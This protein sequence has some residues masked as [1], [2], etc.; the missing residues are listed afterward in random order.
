MTTMLTTETLEQRAASGDRRYYDEGRVQ[1]SAA[2]CSAFDSAIRRY[3]IFTLAFLVLGAVELAVCLTSFALLVRSSLLAVSL[4]VMF[5]T[6]FSYFIL[7]LY[8]QSRKEEQF[9]EILEGAEAQSKELIGYQEGDAEHHLFLANSLVRCASALK[10]KEYTYYHPPEML[11]VLGP[12]AEQ[13]SCWWHW[14]DLHKM[15]ELFLQRAIDEQIKLV[16]CEPTDLEVHAGLANTYVLLSSLYAPP[17]PGADDERWIPPE[18]SSAAMKERFRATAQR[19]IEEF[20]ILNHY[21][22][23]DPWI[24]AQLAYSY[25]DM[26]MPEEEIRC[27]ET[28]LRLKPGDVETQLKLGMLYFQQGQNAKGLQ[29]YEGLKRSHHK[30]AETLLAFYGGE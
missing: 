22:P 18:R 1:I 3:V 14:E 26:H 16:K 4:A 9:H 11:E 15:Q 24:H 5:L 28:I 21:A 12:M 8:F 23:N 10:D 2:V 6:F 20:K 17:R 7:R 30:Q 13:L 19:A 29:V 25:H 27:Y